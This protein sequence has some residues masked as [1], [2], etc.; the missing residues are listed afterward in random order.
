MKSKN[1]K[2]VNHHTPVVPAFSLA[3]LVGIEP[4]ASGLEVRCSIP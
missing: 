3:R 1:H 4:T 2:V